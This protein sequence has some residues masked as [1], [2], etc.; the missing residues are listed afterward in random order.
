MKT[1]AKIP[2]PKTK[3]ELVKRLNQL[4]GMS[5]ANLY[6][7][8]GIAESAWQKKGILGQAVEYF[9]G[10]DANNEA[11][12]DFKKLGIEL[13]TLPL[14]MKS[15]PKE[16]TFVA[17]INLRHIHQQ[18]WLDSVVYKKLSH[19]LWLPFEADKS[20]PFSHRRIG[21]GFFWQPNLLEMDL[22]KKD[23][24][25]LTELLVLGKLSQV[26]ARLGEV[27]QI[28]PKAANGKSLC[29]AF[30]EQGS[31]IQTLPRGFYLR[32]SFTMRLLKNQ[33]NRE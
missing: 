6:L 24:Q 11:L 8:I 9:L 30:D 4:E 17:S 27:L 23:W 7:S 16:S 13:K 18:T 2:P 5:I 19:V 31:V 32:R 20:L 15:L 33:W 28:R 14:D 29:Q 3:A 22:L 21:K 25:E 26:D 1:I 10:A 12:P